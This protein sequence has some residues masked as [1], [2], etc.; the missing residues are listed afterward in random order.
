MMYTSQTFHQSNQKLFTYQPVSHHF[1]QIVHWTKLITFNDQNYKIKP[2]IQWK[3]YY[4]Y[5]FHHDD[6]LIANINLFGSDLMYL[7]TRF[8]VIILKTVKKQRKPLEKTVILTDWY[9]TSIIITI[10]LS[11]PV[12][13]VEVNYHRGLEN[14][15]K[16]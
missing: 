5:N 7:R 2:M 15:G 6:V 14:F 4:E 11:I 1:S 16:L 10:N 12:V 3:N 8:T 13:L 9:V